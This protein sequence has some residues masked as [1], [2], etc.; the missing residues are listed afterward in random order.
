M[1]KIAISNLSTTDVD[2]FMDS[3]SYLENLTDAELS[4]TKGGW[5]Y[6]YGI[7]NTNSGYYWT[8]DGQTFPITLYPM[9]DTK[10]QIILDRK[11]DKLG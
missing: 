6:G 2:L 4:T 8:L 7:Y 9:G 5:N 3:Q 10:Q 11:L 1:A